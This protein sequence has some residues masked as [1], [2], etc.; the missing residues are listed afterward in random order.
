MPRNV[1]RRHRDRVV[2]RLCRTLLAQTRLC[3]DWQCPGTIT[4]ISPA[5]I[6]HEARVVDGRTGPAT[7]RESGR[8]RPGQVMS[9]RAGLEK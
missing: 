5:N 1:L 8:V 9:R 4:A 6:D 7:A 2:L 3:I